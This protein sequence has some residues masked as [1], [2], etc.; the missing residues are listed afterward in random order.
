MRPENEPHLRMGEK[1]KKKYMK[2]SLQ[3]ALS[4]IFV[5]G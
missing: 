4:E 5:F 1:S 3:F 2:S